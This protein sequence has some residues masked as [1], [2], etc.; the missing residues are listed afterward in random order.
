MSNFLQCPWKRAWCDKKETAGVGAGDGWAHG[1]GWRRF[2][3]GTD[4]QSKF[5]G[6]EV[7]P[8]V[9]FAADLVQVAGGLEPQG[10]VELS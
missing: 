10:V 9:E 6:D 3:R 1:P 7:E 8:A 2:S 5:H 4:L